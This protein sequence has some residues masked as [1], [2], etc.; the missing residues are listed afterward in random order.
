MT[1]EIGKPVPQCAIPATSGLTF[2]PES[3]KGKKLVIYFYPKDNTPGCTQEA[4]DFRDTLP[5]FETQN[6]IILGISKD[7]SAQ[8]DKFKKKYGL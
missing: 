1:V 2:T 4:C 6:T 8:H 7:S 3:A 5:Q